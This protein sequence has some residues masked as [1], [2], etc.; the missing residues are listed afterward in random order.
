MPVNNNN[1]LDREMRIGRLYSHIDYVVMAV[2]IIVERYHASPIWPLPMRGAYRG[3]PTLGGG[4][5]TV[6]VVVFLSACFKTYG[7]NQQVLIPEHK[8][9]IAG[10]NSFFQCLAGFFLLLF[11]SGRLTKVMSRRIP[12]ETVTYHLERLFLLYFFMLIY[13]LLRCLFAFDYYQ[14]FYYENRKC[15]M[16]H[17]FLGGTGILMIGFTLYTIFSVLISLFS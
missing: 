9:R 10:I 5:V 17:I 8:K 3:D 4:L 2:A 1:Q 13:T 7:S 11:T 15:Y 14:A 12:L 6:S 16:G